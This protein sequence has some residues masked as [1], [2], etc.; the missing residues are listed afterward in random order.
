[1]PHGGVLKFA[2]GRFY[3]TWGQGASRE[4][5]GSTEISWDS[6]SSVVELERTSRRGQYI[7]AGEVRA[8]SGLM[9]QV[10]FTF[11]HAMLFL[12]KAK[13]VCWKHVILMPD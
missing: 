5:L 9:D 4:V 12:A 7:C 1:M 13:M 11:A 3:S 2:G 10:R 6:R 8:E